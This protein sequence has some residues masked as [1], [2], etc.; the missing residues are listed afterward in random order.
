VVG[1][2]DGMAAEPIDQPVSPAEFAATIYHALGVPAGTTIPG[3]E[4]RPVRIMTAGPLH[5]LFR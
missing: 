2:T 3:P 5:E 1:K 4:G